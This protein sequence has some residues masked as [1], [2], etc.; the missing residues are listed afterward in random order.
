MFLRASWLPLTDRSCFLEVKE[1]FPQGVFVGLLGVFSL[2]SGF[3]FGFVCSFPRVD[4]GDGVIGD[5]GQ[6][7]LIADG[8]DPFVHGSLVFGLQ[9]IQL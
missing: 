5:G 7:L 2:F 6:R 9:L 1:L 4:V 3:I 8:N